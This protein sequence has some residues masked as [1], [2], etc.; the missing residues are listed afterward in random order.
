MRVF[1]EFERQGRNRRRGPVLD[2]QGEGIVGLF[3]QIE[4]GIA[5][6]VELGRAAQR[7]T[8]TDAAGAL[9]GV[10]N[11]QHGDG[12]APLQFPQIG[13]Q[14][15]HFTTGVLIDAMQAHK[16]IEDEETRPELGNGL[17]KAAAN[18]LEIKPQGRFGDDLDVECGEPETAG[19][20]DSLEPPP[21]HVE[22]I[23]G[24][25][26][27]D[28]AGARDWKAAQTGSAGGDR[29]GEI[30]GEERFAALGLGAD[31]AD[32]LLGPQIFDQPALFLRAGRQAMSR[33]DGQHAHRRRAAAILTCGEAGVA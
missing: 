2:R 26:E 10:M 28:A 18:G 19:G 24:G 5:P 11:D 33:R 31:N 13:E 30:Q 1:G 32:S 12:V 15:C 14:R 20:A 27:N 8:G 7:L 4:I 21:H 6:G 22:R 9:L 3:A 17:I 23:L 25:I 29:N 16:G